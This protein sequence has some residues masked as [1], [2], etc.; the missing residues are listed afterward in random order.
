MLDS[1]RQRAAAPTPH[2][3]HSAPGITAA[4]S[5]SEGLAPPGPSTPG[6]KGLM[7]PSTTGSVDMFPVAPSSPKCPAGIGA[8]DTHRPGQPRPPSD[9]GAGSRHAA[10]MAPGNSPAAAANPAGQP[11]RSAPAPRDLQAHQ[12][13]ASPG[14]GPCDPRC[15]GPAGCGAGA[16]RSQGEVCRPGWGLPG[17]LHGAG[18]SWDQL[19]HR[20]QEQ[21]CTWAW[22]AVSAPG[23]AGGLQGE[24]AAPSDGGGTQGLTASILHVHSFPEPSP[25]VEPSVVA[26]QPW[27]DQ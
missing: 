9:A 15:R 27:S 26:Q 23:R 24:G 7:A 11:P 6:H 3:E 12:R 5:H 13:A 16:R 22:R 2:P 17:G 21:V 4:V 8:R 19:P 25:G 20:G 14:P 10:S 18:V 1:P